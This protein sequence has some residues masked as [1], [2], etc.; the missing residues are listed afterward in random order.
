MTAFERWGKGIVLG[1]FF[2]LGWMLL[3][4]LLQHQPLSGSVAYFG[5]GW[6]FV[7]GWVG[8]S[9]EE[10]KLRKPLITE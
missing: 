9:A 6:A 8:G 10:R 4:K 2:A 1:V 5:I 3:D 7:M